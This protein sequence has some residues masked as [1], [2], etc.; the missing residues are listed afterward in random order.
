MDFSLRTHRK[1]CHLLL[2]LL[3]LLL[4]RARKYSAFTHTRETHICTL[5]H[6]HTHTAQ[7]GSWEAVRWLTYIGCWVWRQEELS[8][9]KVRDLWQEKL[10]RCKEEVDKHKLF[11]FFF[12]NKETSAFSRFHKKKRSDSLQHADKSEWPLV[13]K[14]H[15]QSR[16]VFL[17]LLALPHT[18]V[19]L[20][21]SCF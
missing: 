3:W 16:Q 19:K 8:A 5:T 11:S 18:G 2:L 7:P 20:I 14:S 4:P 1:I 15:D 13:M 9:Y 17:Q 6:K 21:H 12:T 10:R